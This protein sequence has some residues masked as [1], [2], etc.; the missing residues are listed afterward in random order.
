LKKLT[1]ITSFVVST[2]ALAFSQVVYTDR[3][4]DPTIRI[5]G[6]RG[7]VVPD[8]NFELA[9]NVILNRTPGID[10]K[11]GLKA[12]TLKMTCA[13]ATGV[14]GNEKVNGKSVSKFDKV[15][16]TGGVRIEQQQFGETK[17]MFVVTGNSANYD[18]QA[19]NKLAKL[20]IDGDVKLDFD[21]TQ[22]AKAGTPSPTKIDIKGRSATLLLLRA[23]GV[24][25]DAVQSASLVGPLTYK[26]TQFKTD[27]E[28]KLIKTRIEVRGDQFGFNA[29]KAGG[30]R[31][32]TLTG[33]VEIK[34]FEAEETDGPVMTGSKV[35]LELN[36]K[37]DVVRL[38]TSS[39]GQG[40]V[41]TVIPGRRK[42][43]RKV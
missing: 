43:G 2:F 33:N 32:V 36:K 17:G 39:E 23:P 42:P 7:F 14:L 3:A 11:T 12:D 37:G 21:G 19:D 10:P 40:T 38:S 24:D 31:L 13:K 34:T 8:S 16:L 9:G 30:N 28:G 25:Q 5:Q 26:G 29:A 35:V 20:E 18:I 41:R 22:T 1:V 15:R 4:K 27:D 6:D